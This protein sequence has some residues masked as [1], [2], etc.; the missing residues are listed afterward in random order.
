MLKDSRFKV[1]IALY[2][3]TFLAAIEG[4]IVSTAMPI[5]TSELKGA[6]LYSWVNT[7]YLLAMVIATPLFGKLSDLYGRKRMIILGAVIFLVGSALSGIA[8]SMPSL[9]VFR[10]IQGLG[11]AALLT[12]PMIIITDLYE[13]ELR[14]KIQG[15][16]SSIW[17]VAGILGPLAG[18]MLVDYVSWRSIFYLNV[19]FAF[20]ALILLNKYMPKVTE[21][22]QIR[23]DTAGI[24]TF[25]IGIILLLFGLNQY[26]EA[27]PQSSARIL[28]LVL[29]AVGVLLLIFFRNVEKRAKEPFMP[30]E[31][32]SNRQFLFILITGFMISVINVAI[33]F[34]IPL[35]MQHVNGVSATR[36][37]SIMIPLSILWPLGSIVAG[38]LTVKYGIKRMIL[39]GSLFL[40]A[41]SIGLA[42][43]TTGT[44]NFII[45]L[46]IA[47]SGFSFGI[48]LTSLMI[49]STTVASERIRGAGM[50][51]VQ[52]FRTLGQAVGLVIFGLFL[53]SDVENPSYA[54]YLSESLHTIFIMI[55]MLAVLLSVYMIWVASIQKGEYRSFYEGKARIASKQK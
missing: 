32:F 48:L 12:L 26:V 49:L 53:Y 8:W 30:L 4:T 2:V 20:I 17:G 31:I 40:C 33:I 37:G 13:L 46:Y 28:Y 55:A 54:V 9:I 14:S 23:I 15:W 45:M 47:C 10:A 41:G 16:V 18:G 29:I 44:S 1:V 21:R 7:I 34:Y 36:S 43:I 35:W 22:K 25:S 3:A 42:T 6:H 50:S 5:I 52:L 24:A 38:N 27:D 11:G 19:P 39:L 51:A